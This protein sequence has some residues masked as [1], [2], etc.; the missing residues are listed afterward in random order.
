MG[1]RSLF[2]P[3][4]KQ[5]GAAAGASREA[6]LSEI[7]DLT[8][9]NRESPDSD[10]ERRLI[11]LRHA[12]FAGLDAAAE[13][14]PEGSLPERDFELEQGMPRLSPDQ[15]DSGTVRAAFAGYGCAYVPGL[16]D[17][18]RVERLKADI[19]RAFDAREQANGGGQLPWYEPFEPD[20]RY[21]IGGQKH[22][23]AS[24]RQWVSSGGAMWTADSPRTMFEV[25][26]T[27][28][29]LGLR[30]LVSD[31][32]REQPAISM[33]KFVLRR[34]EPG[35]GG[36]DWHQDGAFL[37]DEI[38]SI[39]VWLS[40]SHCGEDAPGMDIVPRRLDG[41][42]K[43]GGEGAHFDW[44]VG[45]PDAERAAGE[46]GILR[47]HFAPGDMLLFDHLFLHRTASEPEMTQRRY[48]IE[49]WFFAPSAYPN[50]QVPLLF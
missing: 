45:H 18:E 46:A 41:I 13:T 12:A 21:S 30:A 25:L 33:N 6:L 35:G 34:A 19:D 40:L 39:N 16:L 2:A 36:A 15:L 31:Y 7:S 38:R 42:V 43:P 3:G 32:L 44:S 28:E 49:T 24:G 27:F 20:P 23:L 48:A 17:E 26:E 22:T 37:G 9:E 14:G 29:E 11:Q 50:G 5:N 4:R 1:I 8:E 47:P 10:H